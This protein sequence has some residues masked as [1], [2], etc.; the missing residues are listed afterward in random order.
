MM[1]DQIRSDNSRCMIIKQGVRLQLSTWSDRSRTNVWN[2]MWAA[3]SGSG[4]SKWSQEIT[5]LL[6][7]FVVIYPQKSCFT[8]SLKHPFCLIYWFSGCSMFMTAWV[9]YRF[10]FVWLF[11]VLSGL[12][13][14]ASFCLTDTIWFYLA[15]SILLVV[16]MDTLHPSAEMNESSGIFP[17]ETKENRKPVKKNIYITIWKSLSYMWRSYALSVFHEGRTKQ[18]STVQTLNPLQDN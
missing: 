2:Q 12:T 11:Y 14:I 16:Y 5:K 10:F 4:S 13:Y 6:C 15:F 7:N 18:F 9:C 17:T 8:R 3:S 1:W